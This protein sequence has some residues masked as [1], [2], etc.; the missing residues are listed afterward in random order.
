M[1]FLLIVNHNERDMEKKMTIMPFLMFTIVC[2]F[3]IFYNYKIVYWI[4][5][6]GFY[7][8][9]YLIIMCGPCRIIYY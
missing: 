9:V 6:C 1:S 5:V 2:D 4:I 7:L 8:I 3:Y